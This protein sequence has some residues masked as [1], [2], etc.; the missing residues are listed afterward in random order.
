MNLKVLTL[1]TDPETGLLDDRPLQAFQ[2]AHELTHVIDHFYLCGGTPTPAL[3]LT[4]RPRTDPRQGP[5]ASVARGLSAS[6]PRSRSV[7][8]ALGQWLQAR[9]AIT[10]APCRPR[11]MPWADADAGPARP[12]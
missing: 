4:W 7:S 5:P 8:V 1:K 10:S 3:L 12:P 2:A 6:R 11:T 9:S